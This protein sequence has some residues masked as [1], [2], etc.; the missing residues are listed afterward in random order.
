MKNSFRPI[1]VGENYE[2]GGIFDKRILIIAE[3][4][5]SEDGKDTYK[6]NLLMAEDHISV[7]KKNESIKRWL[8]Y[9]ER[10]VK[11]CLNRQLLSLRDVEQFWHSIVFFIFVEETLPKNGVRPTEK[12]WKSHRPI[13]E[14]LEKYEPDLI[15]L[16][17]CRL[18]DWWITNNPINVT[19]YEKVPG[20]RIEQTYKYVSKKGKVSKIYGMKHPSFCSPKYEYKFLKNAGVKLK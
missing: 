12:Q 10:L 15:I 8:Q 16:T 9:R 5:Y 19:E 6:Y 3:S 18:F 1:W 7:Y 13:T 11:A 4:T 17:A 20:A 2:S 14:V